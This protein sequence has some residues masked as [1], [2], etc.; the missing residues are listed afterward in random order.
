[1]SAIPAE[2]FWNYVYNETLPHAAS[3]RSHELLTED[4]WPKF[5]EKIR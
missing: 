3:M 1:L 2:F 5:T 4:V